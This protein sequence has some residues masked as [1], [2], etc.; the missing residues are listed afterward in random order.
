MEKDQYLL[1]DVTARCNES[2]IL[3]LGTYKA[4]GYGIYWM[5]LEHLRMQHN[6]RGSMK[7]LG[8]LASQMGTNSIKLKHIITGFGLFIVEGEAFYSPGLCKRMAGLDEKR[9]KQFQKASKGGR[10]KALKDR[11]NT[12]ATSMPVEESRA[13]E[14][15]V[16]STPPMVVEVD[17]STTVAVPLNIPDELKPYEGW[18]FYINRLAQEQVWLDVVAIHSGMKERFMKELPLILQFFKEHVRSQGKES[19]IMNLSDAKSYLYNILI[20]GNSAYRK[21]LAYLDQ[22]KPV[23]A[24]RF[25][26][27][28]A[29]GHRSYCGVPIPAYAPPRPNDRSNWNDELKVWE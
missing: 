9:A 17:P 4:A 1:H 12:S 14:S 3:L 18:E 23:D 25:E 29:K 27:R 6:Y 26:R 7:T 8:I 20:P 11:T 5:L 24:Y 2:V 13:E 21:L 16:L 22:H 15:K 19:H 10:A 28:D